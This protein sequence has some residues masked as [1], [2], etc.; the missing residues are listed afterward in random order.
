MGPPPRS[1]P[2]TPNPHSLCIT[3]SI[4]QQLTLTELTWNSSMIDGNNVAC[5]YSLEGKAYHPWLSLML[6][7]LSRALNHSVYLLMS[8]L[9]VCTLPWWHFINTSNLFAKIDFFLL[10]LTILFQFSVFFNKVY[11]PCTLLRPQIDNSEMKLKKLFKFFRI[12]VNE[13][14]LL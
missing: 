8:A 3:T 14:F 13:L 11:L 9:M 6:T 1:P 4:A 5:I 12:Y 10:H 7:L 2:T